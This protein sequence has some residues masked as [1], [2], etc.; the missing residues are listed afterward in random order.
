MAA[1]RGTRPPNAGKGRPKGVANKATRDVRAAVAEI[2]Q[3]NV[4]NVQTW[5]N[6]IA[7]KQPARALQLYLDL[8]EYHIPK[9]ARTDIN[10]TVKTD[11]TVNV[12][13]SFTAP[14]GH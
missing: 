12:N 1:P 7:R 14:D 4:A 2:A 6:R 5:L 9:L 11:S 8:I 3:H 10:A 13:V